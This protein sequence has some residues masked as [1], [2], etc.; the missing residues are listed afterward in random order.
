MDRQ[1]ELFSLAIEFITHI[2]N[3]IGSILTYIIGGI[4]FAL[5][6]LVVSPIVL[7]GYVAEKCGF[8]SQWWQK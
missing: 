7:I 1:G 6:S 2:F 8:K 3:L 4:A 5:F